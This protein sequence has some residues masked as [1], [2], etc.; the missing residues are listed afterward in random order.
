M[1]ALLLLA[2]FGLLAWLG[3]TWATIERLR[4][5]NAELEAVLQRRGG[6]WHEVPSQCSSL[7]K[8]WEGDDEPTRTMQSVAPG[9]SDQ[10][11]P[12][13]MVIE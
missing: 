3:S 4:Q 11:D 2:V 9:L 12:C 13:V 5:R 8:A 10:T 6:S 1:N 7:P